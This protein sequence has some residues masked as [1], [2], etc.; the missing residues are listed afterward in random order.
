MR[1]SSG[2]RAG[3]VAAALLLARVPG[4]AA[5]E[6]SMG[7]HLEGMAILHGLN[8]TDEQ[9][10][11]VHAI[12][13]SSFEQARPA[14]QKLRGLHEQMADQMLSGGDLTEAQF[15]PVLQQQDALRQ[16]LDKIHVQAMLQI[17]ALLT[18]AQMAQA[19]DLHKKLA[20]LHAQEHALMGG[21]DEE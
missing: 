19:A 14:M 13:K 21:D 6:M 7:H 11:K 4:V 15:D 8:L 2:L 20:S 16:Q 18:P 17:R 10:D 1:I 9:R 5:Q 3:A 12:V